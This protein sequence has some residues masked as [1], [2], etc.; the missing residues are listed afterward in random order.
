VHIEH[1]QK[2]A[3]AQAARV[4][5]LN[6][7]YFPVGGR[8]REGAGRDHPVRI[9]EKIQAERRQQVEWDGKRPAQQ[10]GDHRSRRAQA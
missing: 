5:G 8:Y 4:V 9:A 2:D 10:P 1:I 3:D 6:R 7:H